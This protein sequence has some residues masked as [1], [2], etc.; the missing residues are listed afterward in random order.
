MTLQ[1]SLMRQIENPELSLSQRTELRCEIAKELEE[2]G[3]YEDA[4]KVMGEL[5]QRVGESPQVKELDQSTAA[6]S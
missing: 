5:W 1:A 3:N 6:E 2:T 4:R